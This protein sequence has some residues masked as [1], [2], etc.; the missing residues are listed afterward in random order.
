LL[1]SFV[2]LAP[3]QHSLS[4]A[5]HLKTSEHRKQYKG[6]DLQAD[7]HECESRAPV[8]EAVVTVRAMPEVTLTGRSRLNRL[9]G[10]LA[11]VPILTATTYRFKTTFREM[12]LFRGGEE[13]RSIVPGRVCRWFL[14]GSWDRIDDATC[15]GLYQYR[16]EAFEPGPPLELHVP[17]EDRPSEPTVAILKPELLKRIWSDFTPYFS[18]PRD[19]P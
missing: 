1:Q 3:L 5:E 6:G 12:K 10:G 16:P 18:A 15:F 11:R 8:Y 19:A 13:M 2:P 7:L 17:T 14:E 9:L 4:W